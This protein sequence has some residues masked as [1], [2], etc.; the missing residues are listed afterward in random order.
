VG[1]QVDE[2]ERKL[3][4]RR[5]AVVFTSVEMRVWDAMVRR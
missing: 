5:R 3:S 2:D 1:R 4:R